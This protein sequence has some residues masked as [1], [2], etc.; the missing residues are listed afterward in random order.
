VTIIALLP[1]ITVLLLI[2]LAMSSGAD[3]RWKICGN[4]AKCSTVCG[5]VIASFPTYQECAAALKKRPLTSGNVGKAESSGAEITLQA[6]T[7]KQ[8]LASHENCS[9]IFARWKKASQWKAWAENKY[10][11]G[12]YYVCGAGFSSTK[13]GAVDQALSECRNSERK[14]HKFGSSGTCRILYVR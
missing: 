6:A 2:E 1:V 12:G 4:Y 3:A 7:R 11:M 9:S 5:H 8:I 13:K 10:D 14:F